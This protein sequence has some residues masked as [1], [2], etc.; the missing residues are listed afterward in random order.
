MKALKKSASW[1]EHRHDSL[2]RVS[3]I[4]QVGNLRRHSS[5][6]ASTSEDPVR[7]SEHDN[8]ETQDVDGEFEDRRS[9]T[10]RECKHSIVSMLAGAS[11]DVEDTASARIDRQDSDYDEENISF[12]TKSTSLPTLTPSS[13]EDESHL[14]ELEDAEEEDEIEDAQNI[15]LDRQRVK[16]VANIQYSHDE[17]PR[18]FARSDEDYNLMERP[19]ILSKP[20]QSSRYSHESEIWTTADMPSDALKS[21]VYESSR[22]DSTMLDFVHSKVGKWPGGGEEMYATIPA[23]LCRAVLIRGNLTITNKRLAYYAWLAPSL[24]STEQTVLFEGV[25]VMHYP[26]KWKSKRRAYTRLT[27]LG[28]SHFASALDKYRP[29]GS[30]SWSAFKSEFEAFVSYVKLN[31]Y[32]QVFRC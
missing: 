15:Y 18:N 23:T 30:R 20:F 14:Q 12:E 6:S 32:P 8:T 5:S 26:Q 25:I 22:G 3:G 2:S 31:P 27:S 10:G 16:E 19:N 1:L 9:G 21:V 13:S 17:P 4:L 11:K 24:E 29:L 7:T 28:V